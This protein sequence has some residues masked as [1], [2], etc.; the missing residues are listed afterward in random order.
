[1][2]GMAF[3]LF[4]FYMLTDPATSPFSQRSQIAFGL[5]VGLVYGVLTAMHIV[6]G[7]FFALVAVCTARGVW[8]WFDSVSHGARDDILNAGASVDAQGA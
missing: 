3:L 8:L 6:F 2:T 7:F 1:M 4:T 5:S